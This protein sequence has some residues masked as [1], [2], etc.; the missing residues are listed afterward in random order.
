[1]ETRNIIIAGCGALGSRVALELA[2]SE[3]T[4]YLLDDDT[5]KEQN[6]HTSAYWRSHIGMRKVDA[7]AEMIYRKTGGICQT[8]SKTIERNL[9]LMPFQTDL[10]ICS[11]DNQRARNL[12]LSAGMTTLQVGLSAGRTGSVVWDEWYEQP[13]V[14]LERGD[15]VICT[16]ELGVKIIRATVAAA[17]F[18]ISEFLESGCKINFS[19]QESP[20]RTTRW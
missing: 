20:E 6:V 18:A 7:L 1:M 10:V 16:N 17:C 19:V 3:L 9:Y 15:N 4:L 8:H 5:V 14:E 11:F 2:H 13:E 12:C